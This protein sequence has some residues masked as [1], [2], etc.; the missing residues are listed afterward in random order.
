L[1]YAQELWTYRLLTDHIHREAP[2]GGYAEL[3]RL[4]RSKLHKILTQGE[5]KPRRVRYYVERRDP[6][7]EQEMAAAG[8][9]PSGPH[10]RTPT[11]RPYG[12]RSHLRLPI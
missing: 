11:R 3:A 9:S 8:V 10:D 1:G 6:E 4:S 7:F 5:L 2:A 12:P